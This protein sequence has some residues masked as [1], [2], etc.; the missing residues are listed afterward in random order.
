VKKSSPRW[1]S[2]IIYAWLAIVAA[3]VIY[4]VAAN[5]VFYGSQPP[6][7]PCSDCEGPNQKVTVNGFDLYYRESGSGTPV[8]LVH[9]GPG[10]SSLSFKRSFDFLADDYRVVTYDQ[11]GSGN[12]QSQP[13]A[14]LYTVEALVDDLETIR[15]DVLGAEQII[16]IGHSAGGALAQ[17]YALA[18]P[19]H[20]Q[21]LVLIGSIRINNGV[22]NALVWDRTLPAFFMLG[23]WPPADPLERDAWFTQLNTRGA[24]ARLADPTRAD[25]LADTGP[26]RF[27][28]WREVSRS[29]SGSGYE[30]ELAALNVPVLVMYGA[31][32]SDYTGQPAATEICDL[33]PD[34]TLARFENS[35]HWPYLEEPEAFQATLREFLNQ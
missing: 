34:C 25:L 19:Q 31:A 16:L 23:G 15:R 32:D 4:V 22:S 11:R 33:L 2:I 3:A 29:L 12:S 14:S 27:A 28:T 10:H 6:D 18:Y 1:G 20:V 30:T 24:A 9:G 26:I 7:L 35:G 5:L 8:V 17:R 13:D 21:K